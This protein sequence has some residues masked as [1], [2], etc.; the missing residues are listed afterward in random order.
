MTLLEAYTGKNIVK[1]IEEMINKQIELGSPE[2]NKG[3]FVIDTVNS[4]K[5][6]KIIICC[7]VDS[8]KDWCTVV[9]VDEQHDSNYPK[10][11]YFNNFQYIKVD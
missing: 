1:Y 9:P 8:H 10:T 4:I 2:L 6:G 11:L 7:V 3:N 5:N